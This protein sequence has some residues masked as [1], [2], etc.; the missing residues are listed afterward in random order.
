MNLYTF[1]IYIYIGSGR[2]THLNGCACGLVLDLEKK[3]P[4]DSDDNGKLLQHRQNWS[5]NKKG[6]CAHPE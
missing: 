3:Y 4:Q 5:W 2:S 6:S 1:E